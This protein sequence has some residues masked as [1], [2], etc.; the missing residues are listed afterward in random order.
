MMVSVM[1]RRARI[2]QAHM[3]SLEERLKV[4]CSQFL[5]FTHYTSLQPDL[6]V[7]WL[8]SDP[9]IETK[10]LSDGAERPTS[11]GGDT[12]PQLVAFDANSPR[13]SRCCEDYLQ[14]VTSMPYRA[15]VTAV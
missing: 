7:R 14:D 2:V 1:G 10:P 6:I 8:L 4:R 13:T 3:C 11:P 9:I 5:D 15:M 12:A